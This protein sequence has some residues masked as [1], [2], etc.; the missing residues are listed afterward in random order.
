MLLSCFFPLNGP[1]KCVIKPF[2]KATLWNIITWALLWSLQIILYFFHWFRNTGVPL[3]NP[4]QFSNSAS[5]WY[6]TF[7]YVLLNIRLMNILQ[8]ETVCFLHQVNRKPCV[9]CIKSNGNRVFLASSQSETVCFLHQ[10]NRK[11]CVSCIKSI[12]VLKIRQSSGIS[13]PKAQTES[14]NYMER[15]ISSIVCRVPSYHCKLPLGQ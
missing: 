7:P 9:S 14:K 11:P 4:K 10:V 1:F 13:L 12:V 15:I 3:T 2:G 5:S 6:I 8:T